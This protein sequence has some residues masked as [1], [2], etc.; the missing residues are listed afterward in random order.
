MDKETIIRPAREDDLPRVDV[1]RKE[2]NDLHVSGRPDRFKNCFEDV[3]EY[4]KEI[5]S[6]E[7]YDIIV[8]ER[9]GVI[10]GY[11]CV[12]HVER[13]ETPFTKE[14]RFDHVEEF[15]VDEAFR[16]QGIATALIRYIQEAAKNGNAASVELNVWE[17]NQDAIRFYEAVGFRTYRRY[18]EL[19]V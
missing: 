7:E 18:M 14:L 11:A 13:K 17:F 16:R 8:A 6:S 3:S 9:S 5:W 12:K 10:C 2:V 15:C 1:L 19:S 4:L